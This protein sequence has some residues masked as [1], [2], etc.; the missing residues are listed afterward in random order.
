[1]FSPR[2]DMLAAIAPACM[3]ENPL[4]TVVFFSSAMNTLIS[5]GTTFRKACGTSTLPMTCT[6]VRPIA[7]A[8]SV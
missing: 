2:S 6:N 5:G 8:A 1:M 7:R 4:A 3:T